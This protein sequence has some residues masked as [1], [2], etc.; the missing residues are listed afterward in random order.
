MEGGNIKKV[1]VVPNEPPTPSGGYD[2]GGAKIS[3][4][5]GEVSAGDLAALKCSKCTHVLKEPKQVI[6][7]GHRYCQECIELLTSGR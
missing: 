4:K 3:N 6:T 2:I 7:C 1:I 5:H